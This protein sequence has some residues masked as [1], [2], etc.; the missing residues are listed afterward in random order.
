M[1]AGQ[2][3]ALA[4]AGLLHSIRILWLTALRAAAAWLLVGP[5]GIVAL[6]MILTPMIRRLAPSPTVS[7]VEAADGEKLGPTGG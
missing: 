6:Y 7:D 5:L 4:N 2:I 3:L 1:T